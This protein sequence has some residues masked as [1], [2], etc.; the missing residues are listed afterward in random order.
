MDQIF[1][2]LQGNFDVLVQAWPGEV[3][4]SH[5]TGNGDILAGEDEL[6]HPQEGK[7]MV[8]THVLE[9]KAMGQDKRGWSMFRNVFKS[10]SLI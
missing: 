8:P 6:G 1:K 4:L 2:I 7:H 9:G 3:P 10:Q 5:S